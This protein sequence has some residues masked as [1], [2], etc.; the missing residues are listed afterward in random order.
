[1]SNNRFIEETHSYF[2]DDRPV[3]ST[4]Q[5]ICE[6]LSPIWWGSSDFSLQ[7]GR[8]VHHAA[9]LTAKAQRF[10]YDPRIEGQIAAVRKFLKEIVVDIHEVERIM[11]SESLQF[12]GTCDLIA[13]SR[14][15]AA[16]GG[17]VIF[18][19]KANLSE[20]VSVQLGAYSLLDGGTINHGV[21]VQLREDGRYQLSPVYD[22]RKARNEFLALLTTYKIKARMNLLT[23][24]ES[25]NE[26]AK[27]EDAQ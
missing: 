17:R 19:Y 1:M 6:T 11:Y 15:A 14:I 8:A 27:Q 10:D 9:A 24:T 22:L 12:A 13:T 7:K 26:N 23:R 3:P 2:V 20:L 4:T 5:V 21:G 18:D 25:Q 16:K